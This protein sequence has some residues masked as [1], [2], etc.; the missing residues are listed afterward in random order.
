MARLMWIETAAIEI[1]TK[2]PQIHR[3]Q[4]NQKIINKKLEYEVVRRK[5]FPYKT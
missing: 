5:L 3:N 1:E 2:P 4:I